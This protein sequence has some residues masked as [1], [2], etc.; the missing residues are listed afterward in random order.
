MPIAVAVYIRY[1]AH[2]SLRHRMPT[3]TAIAGACAAVFC[4]AQPLCVMYAA[5]IRCGAALLVLQV[6]CNTSLFVLVWTALTVLVLYGITEIISQPNSVSP[7]R[8]A[9]WNTF[10]GMIIPTVQIPAGICVGLTWNLPQLLMIVLNNDAL[11]LTYANCVQLPFHATIVIVQ[12][13]QTMA[14]VAVFLFVAYQLQFTLDTFRLRRSFQRTSLYMLFCG[15]L[16]AVYAIVGAFMSSLSTYFFPELL[17]TLALQGVVLFNVFL[18]L[19]GAYHSRHQ[20]HR[21]KGC[22]SLQVNLDSYLQS[23]EAFLSFLEFC[24]S[25]TAVLV[26][27]KACVD[28]HDGRSSLSVFEFYQRYV[29]PTGAHSV[30]AALQEESRRAYAK[31]IQHLK[32]KTPVLLAT[33]AVKV[34]PLADSADRH[35]YQ[36]LRHELANVLT[37][38]KLQ[39]YEASEHGKEWLAYH[40]RRRS[41]HSLEYVQ[42]V[43]TRSVFDAETPPGSSDLIAA[44]DSIAASTNTLQ[45]SQQTDVGSTSV[46]RKKLFK[47]MSEA[48]IRIRGPKETKTG[49]QGGL[50]PWTKL[51]ISS[52]SNAQSIE[53]FPP[54]HMWL[55]LSGRRQVVVSI[56]NGRNAFVMECAG[57]AMVGLR[58]LLHML[59]ID[60][61]V[62]IFTS[63]GTALGKLTVRIRPSIKPNTADDN[64]SVQA[65]HVP[66]DIDDLSDTE[67]DD[68]KHLE[69]AFVWF[70]VSVHVTVEKTPMQL[71][72][73]QAQ[74]ELAY[75][76]GDLC[77]AFRKPL[78]HTQTLKLLVTPELIEYVS[79]D[80]LVLSVYPASGEPKV[81]SEGAKEATLV[82][83]ESTTALAEQLGK[84]HLSML[85]EAEKERQ[86]NDTLLAELNRLVGHVKNQ[87]DELLKQT[88]KSQ[89]TAAELAK[90]LEKAR[91]DVRERE[92]LQRQLQ[93]ADAKWQTFAQ[94]ATAAQSKQRRVRYVSQQRDVGMALRKAKEFSRVEADLLGHERRV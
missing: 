80:V 64:K 81:P 82:N 11:H 58:P 83:N 3:G 59:D 41:I 57:Q 28:Y 4:L 46:R 34:V 60:A 91:A 8:A 6:S 88:E 10:R 62:P 51:R 84:E 26:A 76:F 45:P 47:V 24:G 2:P 85:A 86:R 77:N 19:L 61:S 55:D 33:H 15:V 50:V 54:A 12:M 43:A 52:K 79:S 87:E 37:K 53:P 63:D 16:G 74:Y 65:K 90:A 5:D 48:R 20:V 44:T 66:E 18:P 1:R 92:A 94:S 17:W 31:R 29:A 69:G 30:H 78:E 36:P 32:K 9:L 89:N 67:V 35:I 68:L 40:T 49:G 71:A 13:C 25:D 22:V 23:E 14:L 39:A 21:L 38:T 73:K 56:Q 70:D 42:K 27:W 7:D 75:S 72:Q 93:D